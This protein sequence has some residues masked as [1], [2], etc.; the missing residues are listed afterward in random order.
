MIV[1]SMDI[2]WRRV[3]ILNFTSTTM[4]WKL[5]PPEGLKASWPIDCADSSRAVPSTMDC[6]GVATMN[7]IEDGDKI[8]LV[9]EPFIG[10]RVSVGG[11]WAGVTGGGVGP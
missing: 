2:P 8:E 9:I 4:T 10:E 3:E 6:Y 7:I 11:V 5:M 1:S